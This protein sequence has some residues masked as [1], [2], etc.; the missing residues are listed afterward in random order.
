MTL[1]LATMEAAQ[2]RRAKRKSH[3]SKQAL[4]AS[5]DA[6]PLPNLLKWGE[7]RLLPLPSLK[8]AKKNARTHS[9]K[10]SAIFSAR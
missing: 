9:K 5:T 10:V 8:R 2:L 3:P 7:I 6:R 4:T 1:D